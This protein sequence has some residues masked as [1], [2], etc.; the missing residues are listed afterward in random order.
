MVV[1][2]RQER[3][4]NLLTFSS[5]KE[6]THRNVLKKGLPLKRDGRIALSPGEIFHGRPWVQII[7][8]ALQP[9]MQI[10][11]GQSLHHNIMAHIFTKSPLLEDEPPD[12]VQPSCP[13]FWWNIL[14]V[15]LPN[16]H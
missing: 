11:W 6:T 14:K 13:C 15:C 4:L 2:C 12:L 3:C 7:I 16:S 10:H 1:F 9:C 8:Y 5:P